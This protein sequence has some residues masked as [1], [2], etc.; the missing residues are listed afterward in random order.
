MSMIK[1]LDSQIHFILS[2]RTEGVEDYTRKLIS[3]SQM[4]LK[5]YAIYSEIFP[6]SHVARKAAEKESKELKAKVEQ[7]TKLLESKS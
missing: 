6:K 3:I 2:N 4:R 5:D 1:L 7:C